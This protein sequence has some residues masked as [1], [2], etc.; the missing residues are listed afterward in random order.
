MV[1]PTGFEPVS[2]GLQS[3]ANTNSAKD[4]NLAGTVGIEPTTLMLTAF[5]S[6]TELRSNYLADLGGFEPPIFC[7]TGSRINRYATDPNFCR[8]S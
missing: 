1:D 3:R 4:P 7:L 8:S 6:T 2:R 5:C